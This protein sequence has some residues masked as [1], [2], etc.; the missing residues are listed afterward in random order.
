VAIEDGPLEGLAFSLV[1]P[2]RVGSS[3]AHWACARGAHLVTVAGGHADA[4]GALSRALAATPGE[5]DALSTQGQDLLLLALPDASYL[6]VAQELARRA[7]ARVVLHTSGSLDCSVLEPLL[8]HGS[9]TGS[10]HPLKAFSRSLPDVAEAADVFFAL[11]GAPE[12]VRLGERLVASWNGRCG[13][14]SGSQ[15]LLYHFAAT[16]A[17]GGVATLIGSVWR[18]IGSAGLPAAV[19]PGYLTLAHGA[20]QQ[21]AA[22]KFP[23]EAITGPAARG[24]VA[25]VERELEAVEAIDPELAELTRRLWRETRRQLAPGAESGPDQDA[26]NE[27]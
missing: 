25:L 2:G 12:A 14:V 18:L 20:L 23:G 17:A 27:G 6:G 1:G 24:D 21:M 13:V 26:A 4:A 15:R 10:L 3:L 8:H 22:S 5:M 11:D 7:Q 19:W 16:L 9:A